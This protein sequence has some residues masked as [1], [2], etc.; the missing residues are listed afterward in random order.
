MKKIRTMFFCQE[1]GQQSPKW[2]G[3]CPSCGEWNRFVEEEV[4]DADAAHPADLRFEGVPQS[5]DAITA[6]EGE[7]IT[8]GIA[9]MDRV[10][11]GGIVAGSAILVGGDPGIGKSTLLL[12]VLEKL[13][14]R[15]LTVLYCLRRGVGPADQAPGKA[16]RRL[17][18]RPPD[19]GG[20]R[21]GKYPQADPGD[22]TRDRRHRFDPDRLFLRALLRAG[23]RGAGAGGLGKAD[24]HVQEDGDPDLPRRPCDEGRIDRRP[25]GP[26]AHGRYGPLLRGGFRPRLPGHPGDQEPLRSHP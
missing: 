5:I 17:R 7:R 21:A 3:K 2:L 19:P 12:Q 25:Q 10:L 16:A 24:P 14:R 15:G 13:A 20:G 22:Q 9:E 8:T 4:R 23:E 11:G 6:D 26:G 1:C 18:E